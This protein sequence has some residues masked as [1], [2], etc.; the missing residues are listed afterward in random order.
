MKTLNLFVAV[1]ALCATAVTAAPTPAEAD[2][3]AKAAEKA[4]QEA[5]AKA[6]KAKAEAAARAAKIKE[7]V[8]RVGDNRTT[9]YVWTP[10][11]LEYYVNGCT[12]AER[13][14]RQAR[15]FAALEE[16]LALEP[17]NGKRWNEYAMALLYKGDAAKAR[18]AFEKALGLLDAAQ[19]KDPIE[20]GLARYGVA[21]CQFAAGDRAGAIATLKAL[22][23][24]S[25][26]HRHGRGI[27][28]W[29]C[30]G[31][32]ALAFLTHDLLADLGLPRYTGAKTFPEAHQAKYTENFTDLST[33]GVTGLAEGD[34]RFELLQKKLGARGVKVVRGEAAF[35]LAVDGTCDPAVLRDAVK[36]E[37]AY[38]LVVDAKGAKLEANTKL[39]V[40]WG[41][42]SFIQLLDEKRAAV[43][44]CE[45]LDWADMKERGCMS[46]CWPHEIEFALFMRI[47]SFDAQNHPT[48][49][50]FF[51]P[52]NVFCE[53]EQ[54]RLFSGF[55]LK[56]YFGIAWAS[57]YPHLPLCEERTLEWH[58][59]VC[60]FHAECGGGVYFPFDDSRYTEKTKSGMH[61]KDDAKYGCA[62]NVDGAYITKLYRKVKAKHPG[63]FMVF[64]PPFY[65]GPDSS[66]NYPEDRENY[67]KKLGETLDPE[68]DVYWTG[69]MV[70]SYDLK[71]YQ[72]D[73]FTKLTKH[74]PLYSQNGLGPHNLVSYMVDDI[75]LTDWHYPELADDLAGFNVNGREISLDNQYVPAA[76]YWNRA[77][78]DRFGTVKRG[79][80]QLYGE[81]MY[82]ILKP[83]RDALAYFDTYR[84]G[85]INASIINEKPDDLKAKW[86]LARDCWEQAKAY[87]PILTNL[88]ALSYYPDGIG[89]AEKV[90][91]GSLKPPDFLKRH[92]GDIDATTALAKEQ[93]GYDPAKGDI[94]VTPIGVRGVKYVNYAHPKKTK[95]AETGRYD[96]AGGKLP[97][98]FISVFRGSGTPNSK[99]SFGFEC[100]P[101]PPAGP[102]TLVIRGLNDE[103]PFPYKIAV[104]VNGE[105]VADDVDLKFD[106]VDYRTAEIE[107][108][109]KAM[110]RN[111]TVEIVGRMPGGNNAGTPWLAVNYFVIRK[112]GVKK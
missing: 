17:E 5:K 84:Y 34:L 4:K 87:S 80:Q 51:L 28:C 108:P 21:N 29:A 92:K 43:R 109:F 63:F 15:Y 112:G 33:V 12:D 72:V 64:C 105:V 25:D 11:Y 98:R 77:A 101:F 107:I 47:N 24:A 27:K 89:F 9:F 61:P 74:K 39:G 71:K 81:K 56:Y 75:A 110:K 18:P 35:T 73:W 88:L 22:S 46:S 13:D 58:A 55:G 36:K 66:A 86:E 40:T 41:V 100:D 1:A 16:L 106:N 20:R 57:Q 102:Y 10:G 30:A 3:K 85:V 8:Q 79:I 97:S 44:Q 82:D 19:R 7:V 78:Y 37:E 48:Y 76:C 42:V 31:N 95:N 60:S 52:L 45:I 32:Q 91:R 14:A 53:R 65:W 93:V 67:L 90:Y 104:L 83:G 54:G 62:A 69:P 50:N 2:A 99:G 70:K 59:K 6:E 23:K 111:N 103:T 49:D 96:L 68:V 26:V 38:R 94:L